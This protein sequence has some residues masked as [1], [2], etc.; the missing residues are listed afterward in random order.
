M[1]P[2]VVQVIPMKDYSVYVYFEDGKIVCYDMSAMIEKEVF[3]SLFKKYFFMN[4]YFF[5]SDFSINKERK[6]D[7]KCKNV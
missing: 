5:D 1:F 3:F 4:K 6:V 7:K 2:K